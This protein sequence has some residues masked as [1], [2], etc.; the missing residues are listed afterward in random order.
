MKNTGENRCTTRS[1]THCLHVC[2]YCSAIV[3]VSD[4]RGFKARKSHIGHKKWKEVKLSENS[5]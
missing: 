4:L 2:D 3:I 1:G 5:K